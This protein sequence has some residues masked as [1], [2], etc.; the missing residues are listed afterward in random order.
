VTCPDRMATRTSSLPFDSSRGLF[1][2]T[3]RDLRQ[4][5]QEG[6]ARRRRGRSHVGYGAAAETRSGALCAIDPVTVRASGKSA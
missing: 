1:F 5:H 6:H 3:V 2:V 4:I